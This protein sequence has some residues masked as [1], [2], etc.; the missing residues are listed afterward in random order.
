MPSACRQICN[1]SFIGAQS[2]SLLLWKISA[3]A[4]IC[5]IGVGI[6]AGYFD[7]ATNFRFEF[8]SDHSAVFLIAALIGILSAFI[9]LI[10]WARRLDP[11]TR[12]RVAGM[13]FAAP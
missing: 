7:E 9:G 4:G 13:V 8:L 3:I 12:R 10:G 11:G 6:G 5:L 1:N 2:K